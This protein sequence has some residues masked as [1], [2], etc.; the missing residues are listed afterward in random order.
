MNTHTAILIYVI[1]YMFPLLEKFIIILEENR[2]PL[3]TILDRSNN[4][5]YARYCEVKDLGRT[6][7]YIP[8]S[9]QQ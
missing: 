9:S 1:V 6:S 4:T 2:T 3:H 8:L 7:P 5:V